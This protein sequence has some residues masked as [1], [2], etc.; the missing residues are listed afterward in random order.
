[1]WRTSLGGRT[2]PH[3]RGRAATSRD[4]ARSG[5][6]HPARVVRRPKGR[7]G[8]QRRPMRRGPRPLVILD[9]VEVSRP[10]VGTVPLAPG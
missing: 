5:A 1:M 8:G 7:P 4:G 2:R 6:G 3:L 10:G 9:V